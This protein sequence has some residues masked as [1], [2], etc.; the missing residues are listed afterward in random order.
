MTEVKNEKKIEH[1]ALLHKRRL[2]L[3]EPIFED[4]KSGLNEI[5]NK[6]VDKYSKK[7]K[8]TRVSCYHELQQWE[9][10]TKQL[11]QQLKE[12][13]AL[14]DSL[15]VEKYDLKNQLARYSNEIVFQRKL[16]Q[17]KERQLEDQSI[18]I[19]NL[20]RAHFENA[21]R[22]DKVKYQFLIE[23]KDS[24]IKE[25]LKIINEKDAQILSRKP[26][27]PVCSTDLELSVARSA[28]LK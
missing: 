19:G 23:E 28:K 6:E 11:Q 13:Q 15:Q 10:D 1:T 16:L 18:L 9:S 24:K 5:I 8:E 14:I 7:M 4:F 3:Q 2:S 17:V 21:A 22:W 12:Q 20:E 27:C 25:Y 26:C